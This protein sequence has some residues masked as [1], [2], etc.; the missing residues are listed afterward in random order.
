MVGLIGKIRKI[1]DLKPKTDAEWVETINALKPG[2]REMISKLLGDTAEEIQPIFSATLPEQEGENTFDKRLYDIARDKD[3]IKNPEV[4]EQQIVKQVLE[5]Q[6]HDDF[7]RG[8]TGM[9]LVK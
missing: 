5:T 8:I 3:V 7:F 4:K 6:K 9:N 1:V 2:D